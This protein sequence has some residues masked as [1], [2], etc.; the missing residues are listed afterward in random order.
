M[1]ESR[2][3]TKILGDYLRFHALPRLAYLTDFQPNEFDAQYVA[4]YCNYIRF[5]SKTQEDQTETLWLAFLK[6]F[7]KTPFDCVINDILK[8]CL[9]RQ[10]SLI[11][12]MTESKKSAILSLNVLKE[13][14]NLINRRYPVL[15]RITGH[16]PEQSKIPEG[17]RFIKD[18]SS[19]EA[20]YEVS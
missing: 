6:G 13:N 16:I 10:F 15:V 19:R 7:R 2:M 18:I 9:Q 3:I 14:K 4:P 17:I 11:G 12:I 5:C 1:P 8:E 20:I